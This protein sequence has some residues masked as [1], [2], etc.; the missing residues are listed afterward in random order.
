VVKVGDEVMVK[1]ISVDDKG[2]INLSRRALFE[3]EGQSAAG[4]QE[5][6]PSADYPFRKSSPG[7][8]SGYGSRPRSSGGDRRP[9]QGGPRPPF[10]RD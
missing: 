7:S 10:K 8:S 9:R 4:A 5:G 1:V 6:A 2:R 3:K